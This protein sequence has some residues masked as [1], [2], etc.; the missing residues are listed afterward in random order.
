MA[1]Y[2]TF[3]RPDVLPGFLARSLTPPCAAS[4]AVT[5]VV[6]AGVIGFILITIQQL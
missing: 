2:A 3:A 1:I 5:V 6:V 4:V